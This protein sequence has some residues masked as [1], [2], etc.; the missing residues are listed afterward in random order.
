MARLTNHYIIPLDK[1]IFEEDPPC[2]SREA[3]EAII[4]IVDW[5]AS[6]SGTFIS[7]F[8]R[9]KPTHVARGREMG[10][11]LSLLLNTQHRYLHIGTSEQALNRYRFVGR[12]YSDQG[13][14]T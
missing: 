5:Y 13:L 11:L 6:P 10:D 9:E 4:D 14:F 12:A 2:M 3:M 8:S 1:L 7:V